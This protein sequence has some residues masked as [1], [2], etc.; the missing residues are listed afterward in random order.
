MVRGTEGE[1]D[2]WAYWEEAGWEEGLLLIPSVRA[3][4]EEAGWEE[5]LLLIPSVRGSPLRLGSHLGEDSHRCPLQG[6]PRALDHQ[7]GTQAQ[8]CIIILL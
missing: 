4:W 5:G 3:Y 2:Y 6:S 7:Q 1:N 8:H